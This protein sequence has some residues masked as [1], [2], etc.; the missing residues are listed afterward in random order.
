MSVNSIKSNPSAALLITEFCGTPLRNLGTVTKSRSSVE[1]LTQL[2]I[3]E[4]RSRY[5]LLETPVPL[6]MPVQQLIASYLDFDSYNKSTECSIDTLCRRT[7]NAFFRHLVA[8]A[9][10]QLRHSPTIWISG[11]VIWIRSMHHQ[12]HQRLKLSPMLCEWE[13]Q[14]TLIFNGPLYDE[15]DKR[16]KIEPPYWYD[17]VDWDLELEKILKRFPR[18]EHVRLHCSNPLYTLKGLSGLSNLKILDLYSINQLQNDSR[19]ELLSADELPFAKADRN[20]PCFD[21]AALKLPKLEE[22]NIE[23]YGHNRELRVLDARNCTNLKVLK[24]HRA[25]VNDVLPFARRIIDVRGLAC[26]IPSIRK[27]TVEEEAEYRET[28]IILRDP[29][30]AATSRV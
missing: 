25:M 2:A 4:I 3:N 16:G 12:L 7:G 21:L 23:E 19:E 11:G 13:T 10:A 22:L 1:V 9:Y 30:P 24:V 15:H 5:P 28:T 17:E 8:I 14:E 27:V 20:K 6:P 26:E 29:P 18:V